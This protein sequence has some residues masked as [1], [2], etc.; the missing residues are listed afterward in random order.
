MTST[1]IA[2]TTAAS[3]CRGSRRRARTCT[4]STTTGIPTA[5][6]VPITSRANTPPAPS[7]SSIDPKSRARYAPICTAQLTTS[8]T[9]STSA[10][11][12]ALPRPVVGP[13]PWSRQS[14][15]SVLMSAPAPVVS[16]PSCQQNAPRSRVPRLRSTPEAVVP[17]QPWLLPR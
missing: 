9:G 5:S 3:E 11:A 2:A 10:M 12:I 15:C 4:M 6:T 16:R 7:R 13:V 8:S 14:C 1:T 17:Q